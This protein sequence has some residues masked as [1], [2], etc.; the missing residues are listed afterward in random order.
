M[1]HLFAGMLSGVLGGLLLVALLLVGVDRLAAY[2]ASR[3][4][5]DRLKTSEHLTTTPQVTIRGFPFLTQ[6]FDGRLR[7]VDVTA[8]DVD[9]GGLRFVTVSAE[10]TG[11]RLDLSRLLHGHLGAVPV[12]SGRAQA[13]V[14]Y[15]DLDRYAAVR[16]LPVAFH[17]A[18]TRLAV[19]GRLTVLGQTVAASADAAVGVAG[20]ALTI[21]YVPGGSGAQAP[22]ADLL[23]R[24]LAYRIDTGR[25]PFGFRLRSVRVGQTGLALAAT[26]TGIDVAG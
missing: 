21:R 15:A 6:V 10:L 25:L 3:I 12:Q 23:S 20:G 13:S 9:R 11:V 17:A 16:G 4:V 19:T 14:S 8:H 22:V 18:G 26:A 7:E 2:A 5:A 24:V 1:R